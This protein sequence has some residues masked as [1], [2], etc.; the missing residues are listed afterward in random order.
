MNIAAGAGTSQLIVLPDGRCIGCAEYGDPSGLPA[1][2]LHGTPGSRVMFALAD[3]P[4]RER[5]I[6]LLAPE[7]PGYGLSDMRSFASLAEAAGDIRAVADHY[8]MR[9]FA[10]IGVSGGGPYAV[11][12]AA[13]NP[14][15]CQLLALAGPVGPIADLGDQFRMSK[16]HQLIFGTFGPSEFASRLFLQGLR[17]VI[18]NQPEIAYRILLQR[19]GNADSEIL[20]RPEVKQSLRAAITEGLRQ[21]VEGAV[22]DV[23]LFCSPWGLNLSDIDVPTILWQGDDDSIVPPRAAFRLAQ[24]L[25]NCRLDVFSAG[26]YWPF[27]RFDMILDAVAASLRAYRPETGRLPAG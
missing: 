22:Q 18:S 24:E 27:A 8:G 10:L 3:A 4:A 19:L 17:F 6:R 13:A 20:H 16:M 14:R 15:R 12:A 23:R 1:I 26:H 7:R 9:R 21:T 2:A 25:P 5:G 11:A